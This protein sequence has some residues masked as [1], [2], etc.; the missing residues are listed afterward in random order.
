MEILKRIDN[1]MKKISQPFKI[2]IMAFIVIKINEWQIKS[3]E[4]INLSEHSIYDGSI[5]L[6]PLLNT[7]EDIDGN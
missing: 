7:F 1:L 4:F 3:F 6:C 2:Y 5:W